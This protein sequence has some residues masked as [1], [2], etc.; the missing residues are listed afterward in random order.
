VLTECQ[1]DKEGIDDDIDDV[2][3]DTKRIRKCRKNA[4]HRIRELRDFQWESERRLPQVE[5]EIAKLTEDD[6]EKGWAEAFETEWDILSSSLEMSE[7]EVLG[8]KIQ[9]REYDEE[10]LLLEL[11]LEDL[12]VDM[13]ENATRQVEELE[14]L[15]SMEIKRGM[16]RAHEE[17]V[18]S[19]RN[20]RLRW[21]VQTNRTKIIERGRKD[22][23][24]AELKA[25]KS[26]SID[27]L[28]SVSYKKNLRRKRH[29]RQMKQNILRS[30]SEARYADVIKNGQNNEVLRKVFDSVVA[31]TKE[32]L[33]EGTYEMR[34]PKN[35]LREDPRAM[36]GVCG[37]VYCVC[38]GDTDTYHKAQKKKKGR[39]LGKRR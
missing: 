25:A 26:T 31:G 17:K 3:D 18:R 6:I 22:I 20:Q 29:E 36:C 11:E 5:D 13:D 12:E 8:K 38:E 15:R 4:I 7:E 24:D 39:G 19:I 34:H 37:K 9:I 28:M 30:Q 33:R 14:Y 21:K 10:I 32:V 27:K 1:E 23:K 16:K 2:K 35:D